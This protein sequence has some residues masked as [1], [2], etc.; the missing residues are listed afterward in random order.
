MQNQSQAPC[1]T[2]RCYC[3]STRFA[4]TELPRTVTYCHCT[5][6]RRVTGAPVA[7]FAAFNDTAVSFSPGDGRA[8]ETSPG[9][10]RTFC[11]RCG[12]PVSGR[13]DYLQGTVYIA[14]GLI[15]QADTLPPALHAHCDSKLPWLHIDD[16]L[17]R[18]KGSA[19]AALNKN[20]TQ[21]Q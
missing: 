13:Y 20:K 17:E 10:R 9:V 18:H 15:D 3:G 7:A 16:T 12:S 11:A 14:I 2:G 4:A 5:D 6:C 19:R 21:K 1:I 8:I